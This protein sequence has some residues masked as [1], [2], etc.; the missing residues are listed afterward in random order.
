MHAQL[1][2]FM[3][4]E[5]DIDFDG[6]LRPQTLRGNWCLCDE[7][8]NIPYS[9]STFLQLWRQ[10]YRALPN[11]VTDSPTTNSDHDDDH[12]KDKNETRC[13]GCGDIDDEENFLLCDNTEGDG[14]CSYGAHIYCLNPPLFSLPAKEELWYCPSCDTKSLLLFPL[15]F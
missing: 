14:Q 4:L 12:M 1:I 2:I 3:Q 7:H 11:E 10:N 9:T 15:I 13:L 8:R 5:I 6:K